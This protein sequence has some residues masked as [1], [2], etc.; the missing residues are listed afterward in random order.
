LD[1]KIEKQWTL[2]VQLHLHYRYILFQ[3]MHW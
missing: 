1:H 3:Q 2:K